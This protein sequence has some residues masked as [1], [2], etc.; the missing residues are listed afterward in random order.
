MVGDNMVNVRGRSLMAGLT[1]RMPL[2]IGDPDP[3]PSARVVEPFGFMVSVLI[4]A[5]LS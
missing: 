1:D 3:F 5:L 2:E 4:D